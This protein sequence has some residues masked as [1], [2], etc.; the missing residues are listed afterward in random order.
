[1]FLTAMGKCIQNTQRE[2]QRSGEGER[3]AKKERKGEREQ[4][5]IHMQP[6][7]STYPQVWENR[8]LMSLLNVTKAKEERSLTLSLVPKFSKDPKDGVKKSYP[9]RN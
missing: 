2:K 5:Y 8:C 1:M 3:E 4:R 6:H 7:R 9:Q